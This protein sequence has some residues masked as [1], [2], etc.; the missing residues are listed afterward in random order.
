MC[1][2]LLAAAAHALRLD[3]GC[4]LHI[5]RHERA[6]LPARN[7]NAAA[8]PRGTDGV[9]LVALHMRDPLPDAVALQLGK[10]RGDR[11]ERSRQPLADA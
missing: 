5:V 6:A 4:L 1:R 10:G 11:H 9:L 8:C 7:P 3:D 2:R